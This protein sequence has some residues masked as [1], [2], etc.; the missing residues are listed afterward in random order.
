M[1]RAAATWIETF[2]DALM[3]ER[4]A[5]EN[6]VAAYR[7]DLEGFAAHLGAGGQSLVNADRSAVE[8]YLAAMAAEGLGPRTRARRLS[9]L[10]QFYRFAFAE[11]WREDDPAQGVRGP[12]TRPTAPAALSMEEVDRLMEAASPAGDTPAR[13]RQTTRL[14]CMIELLYATGLRV[15]E[16]VS[17][18]VSACRGDPRTILVRGK[19][20]RERIVPLSDPA[21]AALAAWLDLRDAAEA[22]ARDRSPFLFPARGKAGH[23]SRVNVYTAL[24]DLAVRAGV[25]P[26][27]MSPHAVRHAFATHLLENGADLRTIQTLLGHADVSTTEIYTHVLDSRLKALVLEKHPLSRRG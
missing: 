2:L 16:L 5:A 11:G 20:G 26:K 21:R 3:A 12:Q 25:D 9:A 14:H 13:L 19:G 15:T 24:K 7:R 23:V 10:R 8:G 18:P 17:L 1:R 4:G 27:R 22:E 6:T